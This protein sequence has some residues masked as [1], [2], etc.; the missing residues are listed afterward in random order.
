MYHSENFE[1]KLFLSHI[2][3]NTAHSELEAGEQSLKVDLQQRKQQ[4]KLLVKDNF[5]CFV[6]CKNTIDGE[7]CIMLIRLC[8]L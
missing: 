8:Y 6:S 5:D 7:L 4:L 2:H 1:P 3:Q